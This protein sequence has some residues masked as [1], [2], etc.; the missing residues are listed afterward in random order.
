MITKK[1]EKQIL[2][3]L[4]SFWLSTSFS[5]GLEKSVEEAF[6]VLHLNA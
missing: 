5:S 2:F 1:I 6:K 3:Y 4:P